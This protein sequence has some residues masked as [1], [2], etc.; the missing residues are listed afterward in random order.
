MGLKFVLYTVLVFLLFSCGKWQ[1]K[2]GRISSE[3]TV[4][5]F[6][7][8]ET[9]SSA[10]LVGHMMIYL[11]RTDGT[12]SRSLH[13][14]D[15]QQSRSVVVP[16]GAYRIYAVG[17]QGS[18]PL[19]GTSSCATAN[20]GA[21]LLLTGNAITVALNL[22]TLNCGYATT[23]A[24]ADAAHATSDM[25]MQELY[26]CTNSSP[27][28][29]GCT[30]ASSYSGGVRMI[31]YE[32]ER[33][34]FQ[35]NIDR[36]NSIAS[37]CY[38]AAS[39]TIVAPGPRIPSGHMLAAGLEAHSDASCNTLVR[40]YQFYEGFRSPGTFPGSTLSSINMAGDFEVYLYKDF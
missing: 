12:Y 17:W 38:A 32:Y 35:W 8:E 39:G 29:G 2:F 24:F 23:T 14:I 22:T 5:N 19:S 36:G 1:E 15:E 11:V 37:S 30:S 10:T 4:V 33:H 34:G 40:T 18:N 6:Q 26:F 20:G 28:S 16:N 31:L 7:R 13:L 25:R 9:L 3:S 21:P 27:A